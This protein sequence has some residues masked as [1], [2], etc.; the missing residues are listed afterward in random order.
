MNQLRATSYD[1]LDLLSVLKQAR[2]HDIPVTLADVRRL[3]TLQKHEGLF[4]SEAFI[5]E[6]ITAY[7]RHQQID[8]LLDPFASIGGFIGPVAQ[9]LNVEQAIGLNIDPRMGEVARLIHEGVP[10][11]WRVGNP[12]VL[13]ADLNG[14]F[15]A[16]I[17]CPPLGMPRLTQTLDVQGQ[18]ISL[19]DE[20]GRITAAQ[21]LRLLDA[22]GVAL[23]LTTPNFLWT[24]DLRSVGAQIEQ[25]GVY[26]DAALLIRRGAFEPATHLPGLLVILKREK[27]D[28]VFVGEL[29]AE[30]AR[31]GILLHNLLSRK[32]G[33]VPQLGSLVER[34]NLTSVEAV[35][36]EY[37]IKRQVHK[38]DVDSIPL[39]DVALEIIRLS[40]YKPGSFEAKP[41]CVYLPLIGLSNAVASLDDLKFKPN[42]YVQIVLDPNKANAHY[43]ADF[44]NTPL[45]LLTRKSLLSGV[46]ISRVTKRSLGESLLYLPDINTQERVLGVQVKLTKVQ[47]EIDQLRRKLIEHPRSFSTVDKA[48]TKWEQASEHDGIAW[49][50]TLPFPLASILW[51]YHA[52]NNIEHRVDYLFHFFEALS[53]YRATILLSAFASDTAIYREYCNAWITNEPKYR[54]KYKHADF[55]YWNELG[56]CLAKTTRELLGD[57]KAKQVCLGL[58]GQ[59]D[60]TYVEMI[61][62]KRFV[63]PLDEAR[64]YRNRWKGHGGL[65]NQQEHEQR[66]GALEQLLATIYSVIS[67]RHES[68]RLIAP[69]VCEFTDGVY[70]YN[71]K[72]LMGTH[73]PFPTVRIDTL[74]PMDSKDLYLLPAGGAHPLRLLPFIRLTAAP[75]T[76]RTACYFYSGMQ[77]GDEVRL[78]SYQF[79]GESELIRTDSRL[80]NAL[81]FLSPERIQD[82]DYA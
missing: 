24:A 35:F 14:T 54:D 11:E 70:R 42:H 18:S 59:T 68:T 16:I 64:E 15:D 25:L 61:S 48:I 60:S 4:L 49:Y 7:L 8:S 52:D 33:K 41:N 12:S 56:A 39:V 58:F 62:D 9:T 36:T 19:H 78:V 63:Q 17:G 3:V 82:N 6:F 28:R 37:E 22:Q 1:R 75:K 65:A 72:D 20:A 44:L 40:A 67:D 79:E 76:Q 53:E 21:A 73:I 38:M 2:E 80:V 43:V 51:A 50:E 26:L 57:E 27:P 45:G 23:L 34:P 31:N 30:T 66:L 47:T 5:T 69:E 81:Q 46:M 32:R 13:L 71:A 74:V 10:I 29:D 55:G 77:S